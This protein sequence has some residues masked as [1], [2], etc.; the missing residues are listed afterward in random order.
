M[1]LLTFELTQVL[2]SE[3]TLNIFTM[4]SRCIYHVRLG[5]FIASFSIIYSAATYVFYL[6]LNMYGNEVHLK[7]FT[8]F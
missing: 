5:L 7:H 4:P 2:L 3:N 1:I 6:D 8:L